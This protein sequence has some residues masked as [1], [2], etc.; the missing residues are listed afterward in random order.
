MVT[1][2]LPSLRLN[3][4]CRDLT[5]YGD[6]IQIECFKKYIRFSAEDDLRFG[7]RPVHA[8]EKNGTVKPDDIVEIIVS[9]NVSF[10][11]IKQSYSTMCFKNIAWSS[12][13]SSRVT[14]QLG[15]DLPM[16]INFV[17]KSENQ[18]NSIENYLR[19]YVAPRITDDDDP[20][21][22]Q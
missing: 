4:I 16:M 1:V 9:E 15:E 11:P 10:K 5:T 21:N 13:P 8:H 18:A 12:A 6:Q 3:H 22:S 7:D 20:S 2:G 17:L 19:F 14:L